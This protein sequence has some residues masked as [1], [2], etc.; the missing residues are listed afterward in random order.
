MVGLSKFVQQKSFPVRIQALPCLATLLHS[1]AMNRRTMLAYDVIH[2]MPHMPAFF[3]T[4]HT[5]WQK[6]NGSAH[7]RVFATFKRRL[8]KGGGGALKIDWK[9]KC[10]CCC[11]SCRQGPWCFSRGVP[12]KGRFSVRLESTRVWVTLPTVKGSTDWNLMGQL[13]STILFKLSE[14]GLLG[15][16]GYP[17]T[18]SGYFGVTFYWCRLQNRLSRIMSLALSVNPNCWHLTLSHNW[19]THDLVDTRY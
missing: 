15:G 8:W 14:K 12:V 5:D 11:F 9:N 18:R 6:Q 10:S 7:G 3:V 4:S 1:V 16:G 19:L 2:R 13:K 17:P